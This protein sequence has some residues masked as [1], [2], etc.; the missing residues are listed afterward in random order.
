MDAAIGEHNEN[1]EARETD[2]KAQ[3]KSQIG[4]K[5]PQ[6]LA[7]FRKLAASLGDCWE[8]LRVTVASN[9]VLSKAVEHMTK[10][11]NATLAVMGAGRDSYLEY[12]FK[13]MDLE[14]TS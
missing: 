13:A 6:C 11:P 7:K 14:M 8:V 3:M 2:V 5:G 12:L 4:H 1:T 9:N 10:Q